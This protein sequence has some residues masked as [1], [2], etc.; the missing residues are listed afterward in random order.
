M[1]IESDTPRAPHRS[2]RIPTLL[3]VA[4][5][6]VVLL[7][8][9]SDPGSASAEPGSTST[10][11]P[12]PVPAPST[13]MATTTTTEAPPAVTTGARA[14]VQREFAELAGLRVGLIANPT[15]VV[16]DDHLIDLLHDAEVVELGAIFAPEH[17][18]R[19]VGGAG[20]LLDD[21]VDLGTGVTVFSLYGDT[22][23]ATPE[24]LEGLDA[25]VYD[26]QDVGGRF[27]TYIATMGFAMEAAAEAGIPF[28]V[29]DRPVVHGAGPPSGFVLEE[30]QRSFVGPFL[31]PAAYSMTAGELASMVLAEGEV[32][33]P[34]LDLR[35]VRLDGWERDMSWVETGLRWR[36]PSPGLP[37]H[38]AAVVYPGTVF[39]EA[40][41]VSYGGGTDHPFAI[42]AAPWLDG[43][44]LAVELNGRTLPGVEFVAVEVTPRP[45]P[46]RTR[47]PRLLDEDLRGVRIVI[48][49]L[50]T[51]RPVEVGIHLLDAILRQAEALGDELEEPVIDRPEFLDLLAGTTRLRTALEAG[52]PAAEIVAS[53]EA[54][55]AG[56][57]ARRA[58]FLLYD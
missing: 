52:V 35:V 12:E 31:I 40:T 46:G 19:G 34:G 42:A 48:A 7:G 26:L 23:R 25:L 50:A 16:G 17:G 45:I 43:E 27:F 3:L 53:W 55:L 56:F 2:L 11:A 5:L 29:L 20:E 33:A 47:E 10:T 24:M 44:S 37:S 1:S 39:L 30:E 15:S 41:T 21:S 4:P 54:E 36:S 32:D 8:C 22:F 58:P 6:L 18:L 49:D 38:E 9:S 57:E 28:V 13:S 51:I 14:L